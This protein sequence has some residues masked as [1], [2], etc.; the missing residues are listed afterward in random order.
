MPFEYR[1][2]QLSGLVL[3]RPR[4][5]EDR[6]GYFCETYRKSEFAIH[7]IRDDFVQDNHS[8]STGGVV[9]GLHYQIQPAAQAKLV[10]AIVGSVLDVAVDVRKNSE[11][12]GKWA[13]VELS[14][15]N[16]FMLYVPTGFAHGFA[17]LSAAA[18]L[19]Y[20]CTAEYSAV[21]ERG[22]R[23]NDPTI[24]INWPINN[25]TLSEKDAALP[26]LQEAELFT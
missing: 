11:T 9:R 21:H 17:V 7:G 6:R 18:H 8:F 5:Y 19:I 26:F 24:K 22:I 2:L 13:A 25:P 15:N 1:H 3:I 12:F 16:G 14:D 4:R 20:K 23:W 10:G